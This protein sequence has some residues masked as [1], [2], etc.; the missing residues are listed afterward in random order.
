MIKPL[1]PHGYNNCLKQRQPILR[2]TAAC[3]M[4]FSWTHLN[5]LA[6][7]ILTALEVLPRDFPS[8]GRELHSFRCLHKKISREVRS[9]D[10]WGHTI[11]P[12]LPVHL[13]GHVAFNHCQT[14]APQQEAHPQAAPVEQFSA[15]H[16]IAEWSVRGP[17]QRSQWFQP[18]T[19]NE[20]D[21]IPASADSTRI[22][23]RPEVAAVRPHA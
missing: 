16:N 19:G 20:A 17:R 5:M 11:G 12:W 6:P 7:I 2:Q 10:E 21:L 9:G 3:C 1:A 13:P 15:N 4:T 22:I 14:S 23:L 8:P 18:N